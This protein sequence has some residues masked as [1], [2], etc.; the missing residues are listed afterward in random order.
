MGI[1][2]AKAQK[3]MKD[4]A[5]KTEDKRLELKNKAKDKQEEKEKE[6]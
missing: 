3:A 5:K 2:V 1:D 6:K 4:L